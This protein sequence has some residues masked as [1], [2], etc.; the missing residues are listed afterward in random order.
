MKMER[1]NAYTKPIFLCTTHIFFFIILYLLALC[2]GGKKLFLPMEKRERLCIK[3]SVLLDLCRPDSQPSH[4]KKEI[5]SLIER[6]VGTVTF[7]MGCPKFTTDITHS[8]WVLRLW[9][10]SQSS[11]GWASSIV[12]LGPGHTE[13]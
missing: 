12:A 8:S 11:M 9:S 3:T 10:S 5:N 6:L 2:G 4:T 7:R 13:D 1:N